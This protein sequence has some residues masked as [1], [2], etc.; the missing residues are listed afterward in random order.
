MIDKKN[1][2]VNYIKTIEDKLI[3]ANTLN[4]IKNIIDGFNHISESD[5]SWKTWVFDLKIKGSYVYRIVNIHNDR[6]YIGQTTNILSRMESYVSKSKGNNKEL[7]KDLNKYGL[8]S[9][10]VDIIKTDHRK[11]MELDLIK[12]SNNCYN[13]THSVN[14]KPSIKPIRGIVLGGL[15]FKYKKNIK[16]YI[17]KTLDILEDGYVIDKG[18]TLWL[19][20]TDIVKYNPSI[21]EHDFNNFDYTIKVVRDNYKNNDGTGKWKVFCIEWNNKHWIFSTNRCLESL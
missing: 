5:V 17:R 9:F 21:K 8:S 12:K 7:I 3:K 14:N 2:Y 15:V 20:V 19:F 6:E 16:E 4:G 11:E 18:S 13:I 10:I 1:A